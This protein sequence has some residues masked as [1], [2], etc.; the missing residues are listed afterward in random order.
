MQVNE[1]ENM[2]KPYFIMMYS[3]DATSAMPI[4]EGNENAFDDDILF[5][6]T[7]EDARKCA[8]DHTFCKALG[9][10]ILSMDEGL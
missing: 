6:E 3:Q 4:V 7:E 2:N 5:F 9:Y 1:G 10:E 8:D